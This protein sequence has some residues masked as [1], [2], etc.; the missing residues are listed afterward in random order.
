M[1]RPTPSEVRGAEDNA[2]RR[3]ETWASRN[4]P[5][6][7]RPKT[8]TDDVKRDA[9]GLVTEQ[10]YSIAAAAKAVG[11]S[12]PTRGEWVAKLSPAIPELGPDATIDE[13]RDENKRL[14][15]AL[16]RAELEREILNKATAF[17]ARESP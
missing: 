16:K 7:S 4:L 15:T 14:K 1:R 2:L 3:T 5:R 13:L 8:S 17:F 6:A 9:V 12:E 10:K 11:V